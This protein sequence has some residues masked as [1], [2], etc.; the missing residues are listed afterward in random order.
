MVTKQNKT[1]LQKPK[2]QETTCLCLTGN[3][4]SPNLTMALLHL[5]LLIRANL[6]NSW[7]KEMSLLYIMYSKQRNVQG[8]TFSIWEKKHLTYSLTALL[9]HL[10]LLPPGPKMT[11]GQNRL[12]QM[13]E[14]IFYYLLSIYS[15]V[16]MSWKYY[17]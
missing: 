14:G 11:L 9:L 7:K 3:T 6:I 2:T 13:T 17:L 10:Q 15:Q 5:S 16:K 12:L 1:N 4:F 8:F